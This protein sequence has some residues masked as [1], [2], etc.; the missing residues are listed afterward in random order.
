MRIEYLEQNV[1]LFGLP[2]ILI[3][4]FMYVYNKLQILLII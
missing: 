2:L 3:I 1:L 4:C